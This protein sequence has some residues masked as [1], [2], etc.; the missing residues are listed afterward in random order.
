MLSVYGDMNRSVNLGLISRKSPLSSLTFH[1]FLI[2]FHLQAATGVLC[3]LTTYVPALRNY[4]ET[5]F[6]PLGLMLL[7]SRF[8]RRYRLV[9]QRR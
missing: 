9:L 3:R 4:F 1:H 6:S 8:R 7:L 2:P 5:Y